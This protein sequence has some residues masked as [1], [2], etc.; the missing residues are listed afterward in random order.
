[1]LTGVQFFDALS[2]VGF[3]HGLPLQFLYIRDL[4]RF[5][6]INQSFAAGN[7]GFQEV[8]MSLSNLAAT[9]ISA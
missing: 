7:T 2:Q 4:I 9:L 8:L 5:T 6:N 3:A 1:M